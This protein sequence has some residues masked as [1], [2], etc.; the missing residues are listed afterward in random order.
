MALSPQKLARLRGLIALAGSPHLEEARTAAYKACEIMR[1]EKIDPTQVIAL[2]N[3]S[4]HAPSPPP[5]R[6]AP[7]PEP[8]QVPR[9]SSEEVDREV[10]RAVEG[11]LALRDAEVRSLR[12][13]LWE[14]E[15]EICQRD[16]EDARRRLE[17]QK[18]RELASMRQSRVVVVQRPVSRH[19]KSWW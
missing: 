18:K 16:Q 4:E 6:P 8:W 13:R 11:A 15:Q 19:A 5:P 12:L 17:E 3:P 9:L 7:A 2:L 1:E 14:A 10:E